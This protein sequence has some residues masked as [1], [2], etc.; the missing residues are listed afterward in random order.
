M[1]IHLLEIPSNEERKRAAYRE[2]IT[3]CINRAEQLKDLLEQQKGI[4]LNFFFYVIL[5]FVLS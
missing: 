2:K 3:E 5:T 4:S 1:Y